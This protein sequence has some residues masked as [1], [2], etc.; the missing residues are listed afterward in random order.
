MRFLRVKKPLKTVSRPLKMRIFIKLLFYTIKNEDITVS[1]HVVP[2]NKKKMRA[3]WEVL[4]KQ[5]G[6]SRQ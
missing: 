3:L 4:G 5:D 2:F 6:N 1:H